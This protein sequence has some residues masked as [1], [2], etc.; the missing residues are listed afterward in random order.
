[1]EAIW[2]K[3]TMCKKTIGFNTAY[4][5]CSVSTCNTKRAAMVFCDE[6]CWDAHLPVMRHREAFFSQK[7][8]PGSLA[9]E[10]RLE[11][12]EKQ[13]K[14]TVLDVKPKAVTSSVIVRRKS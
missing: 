5:I 14:K 13:S 10:Q 1:M 7:K 4:L 12:R 9:E 11:D 6:K 2:K 3:C 8:S